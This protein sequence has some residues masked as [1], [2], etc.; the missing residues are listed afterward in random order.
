MLRAA[1]HQWISVPHAFHRA[2]LFCCAWL[3]VFGSRQAFAAPL[4]APRG[5]MQT[6]R[7]KVNYTKPPAASI[8]AAVPQPLEV[9]DHLAVGESSWAIL[10][11]Q[12]ASEVKVR[13]LTELQIV[14][15]AAAR[16]LSFH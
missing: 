5:L 2:M 11:F 15:P 10:R 9:K 12:D 8:P 1:P 13:E 4:A 7:G 3:M 6:K 14:E 16:G